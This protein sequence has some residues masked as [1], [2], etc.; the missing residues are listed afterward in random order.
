MKHAR[1]PIRAPFAPKL[2]VFVLLSAVW[3]L[4]DRITKVWANTHEVG[5]VFVD[6]IAGLFEF[7]LVHNTGAAWGML[8][9]STFALG[10]FSIIVCV[11]LLVILFTYIR[12]SASLASAV[13]LA[14]IFAGGLGNA[15]DRLSFS[16]VIDFINAKFISFPVFNVAD[17]GV[18]C[19]IALLLIS[20]FI[21]ERRAKA[22]EGA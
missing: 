15:I 8:A 2:V 12:T 11:V 14:L 5:E 16:Y 10:I 7:R 1:T 19:G 9:D 6:D 18:T 20:M 21:H 17:I 13:F 22:H 4:L 3:L